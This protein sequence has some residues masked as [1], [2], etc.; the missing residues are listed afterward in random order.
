MLQC[1]ERQNK[2]RRSGSSRHGGRPFRSRNTVTDRP[3]NQ[4]NWESRTEQLLHECFMSPPKMTQPAMTPRD[5]EA[6]Q[7]GRPR[8]KLACLGV[9]AWAWS[10][11]HA[12][13]ALGAAPP[14]TVPPPLPFNPFFF[15]QTGYPTQHEP[16]YYAW[17]TSPFH[18]SSPGIE[19]DNVETPTPTVGGRC[20]AGVLPPTLTGTLGGER[21][22]VVCSEPKGGRSVFLCVLSAWARVRCFCTS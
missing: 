6:R 8:A 11:A 4:T 15:R 1:E 14:F 16:W 17:F 9:R 22:P 2:S 19:K 3:G 18:T 13:L 21:P 10:F 20:Q 12:S 5:P 7:G